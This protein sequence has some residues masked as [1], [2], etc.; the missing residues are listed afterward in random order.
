MIGHEIPHRA[1]VAERAAYQA[2]GGVYHGAGPG[3]AALPEGEVC[4]GVGLSF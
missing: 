3:V 4:E 2:A 1:Q